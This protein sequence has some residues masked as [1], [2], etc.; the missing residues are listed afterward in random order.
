MQKRKK[1]NVAVEGWGSDQNENEAREPLRE[2]QTLQ[3]P[4]SQG[5]MLEFRFYAKTS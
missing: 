5:T 4:V 1:T 3:G 2:G